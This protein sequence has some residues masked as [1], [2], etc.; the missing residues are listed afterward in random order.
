M[1]ITDE[2]QFH[3]A[4]LCQIAEHEQFTAINAVHFGGIVSRS[5]Y[6]INDSIFTYLK[7]C[8][9]KNANGEF[10]FTFTDQNKSELADLAKKGKKVFLVLVCI[11]SREICVYEYGKFLRT[12]AK[13]EKIQGG[14]DNATTLL[15]ELEPNKSFRV[16]MNYPGKKNLMIGQPDVVARKD[17]PNVLFD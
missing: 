14:P 8:T 12:L 17:F 4:A 3:G 15:V 1:K 7:Y 11:E 2:H 5:A 10:V 6:R 13:R 16:F 9:Y